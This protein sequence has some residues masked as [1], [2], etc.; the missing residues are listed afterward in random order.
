MLKRIIFDIV[1]LL[2]IFLSP[3]WWLPVILV[4]SFTF[5]FPH[6]WEAVILGILIDSVNGPSNIAFLGGLSNWIFTLSFLMILLIVGKFKKRLS[7]YK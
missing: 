5:I 7:L 1:L 6:F 4:I 2:G 3:W